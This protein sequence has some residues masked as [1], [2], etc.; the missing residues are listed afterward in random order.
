M[1]TLLQ[2]SQQPTVIE[3]YPHHASERKHHRTTGTGVN[4]RVA[5]K[6]AALDLLKAIKSSMSPVFEV[7]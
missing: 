4:K 2:Y 5:K 7:P 3:L 1:N 6:I